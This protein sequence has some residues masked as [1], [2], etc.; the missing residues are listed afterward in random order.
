MEGKYPSTQN[1]LSKKEMCY[2]ED[3]PN[4]MYMNQKIHGLPHAI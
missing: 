4:Y 1:H 3:N 2:A